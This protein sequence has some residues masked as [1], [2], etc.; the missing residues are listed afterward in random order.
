MPSTTPAARNSRPIPRLQDV[1]CSK[2]ARADGVC[3]HVCRYRCK[4][5]ATPFTIHMYAIASW[6]P[7]LR[8][9]SREASAETL[10][11][12]QTHRTRK[13]VAQTVAGCGRP[14]HQRLRPISRRRGASKAAAKQIADSHPPYVAAQEGAKGRSQ[15]THLSSFFLFSFR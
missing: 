12:H 13:P 10:T 6:A 3:L 1:Q 4:D 15:R 14:R 2:R 9:R 7:W 5:A 11:P 8:D